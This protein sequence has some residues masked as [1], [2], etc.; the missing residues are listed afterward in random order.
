MKTLE[1][2]HLRLAGERRD[3]LVELIHRAIPSNLEDVSVY[4]FRHTVFE[5]D[6]AVHLTSRG[7]GE[8]EERA[9]SL[10]K[11][12]AA[13]LR[14]HGMVEHSTWVELDEEEPLS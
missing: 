12:I 11:R 2:V 1:I 10:G 7:D 8:A 9:Q 14:G 3:E 4:L 6:I 13:L 5:T